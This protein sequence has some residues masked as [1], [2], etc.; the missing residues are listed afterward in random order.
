M[1][2]PPVGM[3]AE[4]DWRD[5]PRQSLGD[6]AAQARRVGVAGPVELAREA[7]DLVDE[8]MPDEAAMVPDIREGRA[9]EAPDRNLRE[10]GL[11][12]LP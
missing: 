4:R 11:T 3:D 10:H 7:L 12:S 5:V 1:D 8:L 6:A 2:K 9:A